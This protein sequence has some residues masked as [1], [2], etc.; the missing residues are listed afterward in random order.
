MSFISN[1]IKE[2]FKKRKYFFE[3][4]FWGTL[5]GIL[6]QGLNFI[7]NILIARILGKQLLGEY[8]LFISAN[9]GLHTFGVIKEK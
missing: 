3:S 9:A 1:S 7:A 5:A 6:S 4:L 2:Q 8:T